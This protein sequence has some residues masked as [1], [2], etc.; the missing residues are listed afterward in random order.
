M[1][2]GV[3]VGEIM[4]SCPYNTVKAILSQYCGSVDKE[5]ISV[6]ETN[7]KWLMDPRNW[8]GKYLFPIF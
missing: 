5:R 8:I 2:S 4:I 6:V 3:I 7:W 1:P